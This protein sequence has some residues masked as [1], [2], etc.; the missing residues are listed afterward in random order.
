MMVIVIV[1]FGNNYGKFELF[2]KVLNLNIISKI[3]FLDFQYNCVVF[4][5]K[6][7]WVKMQKVVLEILKCYEEICFCG[8]GRNDL[9]GYSVRYCVYILMEYVINVVVD[10][11]VFDKREI[12]GNFII[13][14]KEGLR[15]LLQR[16]KDKFLFSEICIDVFVII[17]KFIRDMKGMRMLK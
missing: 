17:I 8:D 5:V 9:F 2:C 3:I 14:E 7:V 15:R 6:D 16:L 10:F 4:V 11:E 12:G 1:L 13:M